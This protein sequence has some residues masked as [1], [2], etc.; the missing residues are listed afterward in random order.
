MAL[1]GL[2]TTTLNMGEGCMTVHNGPY[3]VR[4]KDDCKTLST[5]HVIHILASIQAN[6][7]CSISPK[8]MMSFFKNDIA[9]VNG[10]LNNGFPGHQKEYHILG[11]LLDD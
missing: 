2:L 7:L 8:M 9:Q 6:V 1:H 3:K 10:I 4:I 5:S 11:R